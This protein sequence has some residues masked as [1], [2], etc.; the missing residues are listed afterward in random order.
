MPLLEPFTSFTIY[1]LEQYEHILSE[2]EKQIGLLYSA[3]LEFTIKV[4]L[5]EAVNNSIEHGQLPITINFVSNEKEI[6]I[7]V[8]DSGEGFKVNQKL[9]LI[10]EKGIDD[11]LE[12]QLFST[13]GR[14]IYMMY[15]M[16]SKVVFNEKGNEVSLIVQTN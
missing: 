11:L 3:N 6:Q 8:K 5:F 12:E 16:V 14:G 9:E 10:K 1:D 7:T 4:A 15:K 2:L 13:R